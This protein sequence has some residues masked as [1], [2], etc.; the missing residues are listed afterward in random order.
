MQF[1]ESNYSQYGRTASFPIV[2][3]SI[4]ILVQCNHFFSSFYPNSRVN[5]DGQL[6]SMWRLCA[7]AWRR[8]ERLGDAV[9]IW[10]WHQN[11]RIFCGRHLYM[12][13]RRRN[14]HLLDLRDDPSIYSALFSFLDA[15]TL[16][17]LFKALNWQ[18]M[19]SFCSWNATILCV[20]LHLHRYVRHNMS[21]CVNSR[22]W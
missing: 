3:N 16:R 8:V 9:W 7:V 15:L 11:F 22:G 6:V 14:L 10:K 17:M 1:Y 13:C 19:L 20:Y 18:T 21:K 4:H 2:P 5:Y 12:F